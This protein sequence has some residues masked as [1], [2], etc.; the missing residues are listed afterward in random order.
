MAGLTS[1]GFTPLQFSEIVENIETR[2]EQ[3]NPGFDFTPDSPDGQLI[4]IM[5]VLINQ[6]W[7]ELNRVY[8]SYNPNEAY[9]QGL[10]NLGMITGIY[11]GA[12]TRSQ[13]VV[14]LTG[15]GNTKVPK[16]SIMADADGNE[17]YTNRDAYLPADVTVLSVLSG[18]LPV[19]AGSITD[20][21]SVVGGWTGINQADDGII[22]LQPETDLQYRVRRNNTVM[23][24]S[25][26]V[27]ESMSAAI[28]DLGIP[29]VTVINNDSELAL[30]DGTP[31]HNI[32]VLI[33]EYSGIS[34]EEIGQAIFDNKGLGVPTHGTTTVSI[35]D[36]F[37]NPHDVLFTPAIEVPIFFNIEVTYHSVEI[38]GADEQIK[39]N[40]CEYINT[41]AAGEDVI[42]SGLFCLIT[43]VAKAEVNLLEIGTSAGA[44]AA[45]N[46]AISESEYASCDTTNIILTVL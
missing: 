18:P 5:S 10:K 40:L 20:I 32:H 3:Y 30:A 28:I 16:G 46:V 25:N 38:A 21:I 15:T 12:A 37:G 22:G 35:D 4:S 2:L 13:A 14:S 1:E 34:D 19:P 27:E 31:A 42:W 11:K 9:G 29:Q 41:L 6:A 45:A 33:G 26:T 36:S 23:R 43:P 24:G 7:I 44:V 39:K 8:H 17:F